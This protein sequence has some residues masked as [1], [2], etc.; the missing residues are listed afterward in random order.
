MKTGDGSRWFLV[1]VNVH[2]R[3]IAQRPAI[4]TEKQAI[5]LTTTGRIG[6]GLRIRCRYDVPV[7]DLEEISQPQAAILR[8]RRP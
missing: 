1:V 6:V 7:D 2:V 5:E 3:S 8:S 4:S